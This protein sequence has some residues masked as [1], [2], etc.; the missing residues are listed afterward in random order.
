MVNYAPDFCNKTL[1]AKPTRAGSSVCNLYEIFISGAIEQTRI[2]MRL[3]LHR[4]PGAFSGEGDID[5]R[6]KSKQAAAIIIS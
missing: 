4:S 6:H 3:R 5:S 1:E 2:Y